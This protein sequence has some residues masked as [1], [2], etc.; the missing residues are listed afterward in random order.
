MAVRVRGRGVVKGT[1]RGAALLSGTPIS[2][3]GDLDIRT[4]RVTGRLSDLCGR[5]IAGRILVVPSTRGS[6]GAWRFIHQLRQHDTHPLALLTDELPDPSVVQGAILSGI[7]VIAGV[8]SAVGRVAG[9]NSL[10]AVDGDIGTVDI[11]DDS[12]G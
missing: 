2:F 10:L 5:V 1:A 4:G 3:L 7:P 6:A 11:L 9:D 8:A 12:A